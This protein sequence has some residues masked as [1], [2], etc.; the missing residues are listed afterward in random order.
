M[1]GS[2]L[3]GWRVSLHRTRADWPIVA[4]AWLITLLAAVLFSAGLIYPSA[5]AEAGLRRALTDAPVADAQIQVSLYG[6]AADA[7]HL[8]EVVMPELGRATAS[9]SGSVVRD[10]QG[11]QTLR[12]PALAGIEPEDQAIVGYM[13][14]LADHATLVGGAW[15]VDVDR[16]AADKGQ[17]TV[18]E[19]DAGEPGDRVRHGWQS[20]GGCKI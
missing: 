16:L 2:L 1:V 8:D 9:L 15:P 7:P 10:W 4:A 11:S 19:R 18:G 12:L 20:R 13:D 3:A 14:G 17:A 6:T 5:A